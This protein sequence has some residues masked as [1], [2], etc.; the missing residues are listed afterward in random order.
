MSYILEAL[1]RADAERGASPSGT[2]SESFD[3]EKQAQAG[4]GLPS[5]EAVPGTT[6]RSPRRRWVGW[7]VAAGLGVLTA[8]TYFALPSATD[9][10]VQMAQGPEAAQVKSAPLNTPIN[11]PATPLAA[12]PRLAPPVAA[13]SVAPSLVTNQQPKALALPAAPTQPY[14]APELAAAP[15][16]PPDLSGNAFAAAPADTSV[17]QTDSQASDMPASVPTGSLVAVRQPAHAAGKTPRE[18]A[19][20]QL[21]P[22]ILKRV[23]LPPA[24]P[25]RPK[26]TVTPP[27]PA[28]P[29]GVVRGQADIAISGSSYSANPAHR[30]LIANGKVVKEGQELAPG[31]TLEV[32]G[33]RSAVFNQGGSRFNVNY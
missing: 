5:G 31:I 9:E 23:P 22:Q 2:S 29:T 18:G 28:A 21:A 12:P 16:S 25:V 27:P 30:M 6:S 4:R 1:K 15:S 17:P 14:P 11:P 32:I 24:P 33:P 26:T 13:P 20:P 7:G 19:P 10:G 3:G 8:V